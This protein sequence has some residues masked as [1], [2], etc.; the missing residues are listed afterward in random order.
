MATR[1]ASRTGSGGYRTISKTSQVDETLFGNPKPGANATKTGRNAKVEVV[2]KSTASI[3][4]ASAGKTVVSASDIQRM[5][6]PSTILS[7]EEVRTIKAQNSARLEEERK[8]ATQKKQNMLLAEEERKRNDP[9][10]ETEQKKQESD[11]NTKSRATLLLEEE[12]DDVKRMNQMMLYSKCVT[13]R[14]AQLEEKK[15][16]IAE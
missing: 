4:K 5:K 6:G 2:T 16:M 7:P 1:T 14:D 15:N 11:A 10:T 12:L 3:T 13:I 9:P 8:F